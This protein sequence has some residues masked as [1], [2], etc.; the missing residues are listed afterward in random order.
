MFEPGSDA[1]E[2]IALVDLVLFG[3]DQG[4]DEHVGGSLPNPPA[5]AGNPGFKVHNYNWYFLSRVVVSGES[6]GLSFIILG[7]FSGTGAT[8]DK[9]KSCKE[10][11]QQKDL[12]LSNIGP[13]LVELN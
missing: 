12:L 11:Q 2:P 8:Q 1:I 3:F 7:L 4:G 10:C 6:P 9:K 13:L 5:V